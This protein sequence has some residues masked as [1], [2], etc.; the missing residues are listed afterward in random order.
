[1]LKKLLS[2][3]QFGSPTT[4]LIF[5]I[6][7]WFSMQF[8]SFKVCWFLLRVVFVLLLSDERVVFSA[9]IAGDLFG[10]LLVFTN[11]NCIGGCS[12]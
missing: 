12:Y 7:V 3:R 10:F 2:S 5:F 6:K 9:A 4:A 1:M 11:S 8:F